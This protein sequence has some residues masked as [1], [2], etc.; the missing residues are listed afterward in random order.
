[1]IAS[2]F[3]TV[4]YQPL[5]NGLIFLTSVVPGADVGIAV[6]LLTIL[7]K[8]IL[9]PFAHKSTK[10]QAA[11]RVL[12][13]E[14]KE[15]KERHKDDKQEQARKTMELYAR[16]GVSP[17]S[18][19]LVLIIQLPIII[20]LYWVFFK[21]LKVDGSLI[22][23]ADH[24]VGYIQSALLNQ[25][26]L[27]SFVHIPDLIKINFLGI[28]D[29]T[30][31]SISLALLAGISQYFQIKLSMPG[32]IGKMALKSTGSLKDDLA[33]SMKFQM[34]YILP[35]FVAVFAY[36]ISAAVALYWVTSN[37][38]TIGHELFVRRKAQELIKE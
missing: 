34:R 7:V 6:V 5:Y 8:A 3:N 23:A 33:Q 12:E 10:A 11:L 30:G 16:H 2:I 20:A 35:V 17:F 29:M 37:V 15:L 1:M 22:S 9:F 19:C 31:K 24:A 38:F 13:P 25:E 14:I 4:L 18:G 28:I 21:G 32:E 36:S 26:I 27:Y